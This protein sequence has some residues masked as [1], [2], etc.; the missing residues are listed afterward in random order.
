MAQQLHVPVLLDDKLARRAASVLNIP[1]IGTAGVLI[2]G[3]QAG[4]IPLVKPLL[5]KLKQ[6]GYHM[7]SKLI[8]RVL[9][10]AGEG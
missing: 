10:L 8:Q 2:K 5:G 6:E 1:V 9:E 4:E 7:S 3:K